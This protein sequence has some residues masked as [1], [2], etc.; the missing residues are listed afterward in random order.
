MLVWPFF[1]FIG[2][3]CCLLVLI[4]VCWCVLVYVG[5]CWCVLVCVEGWVVLLVAGD[6]CFMF[7]SATNGYLVLIGAI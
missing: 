1:V 3:C 6:C 4:A 7:Q 2:V 5:V